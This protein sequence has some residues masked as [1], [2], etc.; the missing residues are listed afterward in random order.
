M[1]ARYVLS[2]AVALVAA[3][4][5]AD[6]RPEPRPAP[7]PFD[8]TAVA[9]ADLSRIAGDS[10]APVWVVIVSDF[11]CPFCKVWHDSTYRAV[12]QEFV[13]RGR[14]RLAYLHMPL[15]QHQHAEITAE[16]AMCAG[17]Q[18]RFWEMHDVLFATQ[19][20][21]T[22]MSRGTDYFRSLARRVGVD[23]T[24]I[25]QCLDS[26]VMRGLVANDYRRAVDGGARSTPSFFVGDSLIVGVR[27]IAQFRAVIANEMRKRATA[28]RP[29]VR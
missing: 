28:G 11:Q 17:E 18:G 10:S 15:S 3:C 1:P 9:R 19:T 24:R 8:S 5:N 26:G 23:T 20:E 4:A 22:P 21:W 16:L 6:S 27:P 25:H 2:A 13:D 29:G 14:V 12:R 7:V